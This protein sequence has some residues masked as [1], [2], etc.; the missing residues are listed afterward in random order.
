[1]AILSKTQLDKIQ[2]IVQRHVSWFVWRLFGEKY[3]PSDPSKVNVPDHL[4]TQLPAS[5]TKLAFVLGREEAIMKEAEWGAYEWDALISAAEKKLTAVE[6]VQVDTA[7]LS[8]YSK[9]RQLGEEISN[10]VFNRLAV[11]TSR[12]VSEGQ[13]RGIIKDQVQLGVETNRRYKDVAKDL[14]GALKE[15]QK[16][17][18]RV[19]S[20]E[21]HQSRQMGIAHAIINKI[22]FYKDSDG[23]D[24]LVAIVPAPDACKDCVRLYVEKGK[25]KVFKLSEL[26]DNAGSNYQ[27]PWREN[28]RPVVP[29]LHP[30]CFCR[31]RYV[32]PGW[33]WNDEGR[34]T[35]TDPKAAYPEVVKGEPLS[36]G[37]DQNAHSLLHASNATLPTE[38]YVHQ[39]Q[40]PVELEHLE[41]RLSKL[42][43]IYIKD[44]KVFK[45]IDHLLNLV[46][47]KHFHQHMMSQHQVQ[48]GADDNS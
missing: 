29:P 15:N 42:R 23:P 34:F 13:V 43:K 18:T 3:S 36:K 16:N 5:L 11:E 20:T 6:Q 19:A 24:S 47:G 37:I 21:M 32:P 39:I 46:R 41:R 45:R 7:E 26:L 38:D 44:E 31:L 2:E 22:D 10:G 48:E 1:M 12:V 33:G 9:Y 4:S 25:P 27:R 30:H 40:D 8:A 14:A 35:L 17:W 28:A